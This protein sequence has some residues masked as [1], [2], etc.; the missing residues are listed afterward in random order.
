[1]KKKKWLTSL[2]IANTIEQYLKFCVYTIY[3]FVYIDISVQVILGQF[4][5]IHNVNSS[6]CS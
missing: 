5:D 4:L 6:K 3:Q 2:F 1:M